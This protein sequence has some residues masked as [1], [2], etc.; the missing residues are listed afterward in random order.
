MRNMFLVLVAGLFAATAF[1]VGAGVAV[2]WCVLFALATGADIALPLWLA[3][4]E[5]LAMQRTITPQQLISMAGQG[6]TQGAPA[7][8]GPTTLPS[9]ELCQCEVCSSYKAGLVPD[10]TLP[11]PKCTG[12]APGV[13]VSPGHTLYTGDGAYA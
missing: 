7:S 12:E 1:G 11:A 13:K 10:G 4:K 6:P 9:G 2:A 3:R 5:R 8:N